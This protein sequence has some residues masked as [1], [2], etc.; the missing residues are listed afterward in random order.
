MDR[1]L[2]PIA[3]K[4]TS[5]QFWRRP[6]LTHKITT[7]PCIRMYSRRRDETKSSE[8]TSNK[9]LNSDRNKE[10]EDDKTI[11]FRWEWELVLTRFGVTD[12]PIDVD[13]GNQWKHDSEFVK[14]IKNMY[15]TCIISIFSR[16]IYW[17]LSQICQWPPIHA[18]RRRQ[19][20]PSYR[21]RAAW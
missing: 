15:D 3:L 21:R 6:L 4:I 9:R 8:S 13:E 5:F 10:E 1:L 14:M 17:E 2:N 20:Q 16:E 11:E 12:T 19:R 7:G 18:Y